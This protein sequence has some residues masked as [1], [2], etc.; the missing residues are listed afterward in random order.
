M[1]SLSCEIFLLCL[2]TTV[3]T[4][5]IV[6]LLFICASSTSTTWERTASRPETGL[7]IPSVA[8][9]KLPFRQNNHLGHR[10]C[11][12]KRR[13]LFVGLSEGSCCPITISSP[14]MIRIQQSMGT[15]RLRL[16]QCS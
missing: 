1:V 3:L 12:T 5:F 2:V 13:S 16:F 10:K 8:V 4:F 6:G 7:L 15:S 14:P 11:L 9:A